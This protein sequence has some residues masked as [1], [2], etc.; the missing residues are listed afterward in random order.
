MVLVILLWMLVPST[1]LA[2]T[3]PFLIEV[4]DE[5]PVVGE[6]F[7]VTVR[8]GDPE[9][10]DYLGERI[11]ELVGV[12]PAG[13]MRLSQEIPISLQRVT[14]SVYV[15]EVVFPENGRWRIWS[16]PHL[17][18]RDG[19]ADIYT[20][21]VDVEVVAPSQGGSLLGSLVVPVGLALA[22]MFAL[23]AFLARRTRGSLPTPVV[24]LPRDT[25]ERESLQR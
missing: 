14:S 9:A 16:F 24:E 6:P 1:A 7:E 11:D 17:V 18:H 12:F 13:T 21:F 19:I 8:F 5:P 2:K 22:S 15:G 20:D 23:V 25:V 4:P 10:G 3:P